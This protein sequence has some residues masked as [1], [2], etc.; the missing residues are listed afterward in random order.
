MNAIN[1]QHLPM[2]D[3][4]TRNIPKHGI[5]LLSD[6]PAQDDNPEIE[7]PPR[8][9]LCL[10][11]LGSRYEIGESST[12][13]PTRDRGIDY[14]FVSNLDAKARRQGIEE[15]G[16]GIRDTWVDP[17][18]TVPEIAPVKYKIFESL[19]IQTPQTK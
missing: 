4:L 8:K 16:Y 9:R 17:A 6:K 3:V 2:N 12:A 19:N 15:G 10:S 1:Y 13:R 18:E 5:R 7:M 11:T 14:G